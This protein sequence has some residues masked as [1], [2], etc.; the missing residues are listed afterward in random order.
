M[1]TQIDSLD[2]LNSIAHERLVSDHPFKL[3]FD[4]RA[5]YVINNS[6]YSTL[7]SSL[8][9]G[10]TYSQYIDSTSFYSIEDISSLLST[11][12]LYGWNDNTPINSIFF[13]PFSLK[14]FYSDFYSDL[15]PSL[16]SALLT[17]LK[18]TG[19]IVQIGT[20]YGKSLIIK[21]QIMSDVHLQTLPSAVDPSKM[22]QSIQSVA[23]S[24]STYIE[25]NNYLLS[26][27]EEKNNTINYLNN[28]IEEL[29]KRLNLVY[30]TTWR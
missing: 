28:Q 9:N 15:T 24:L 17:L 19:R 26:V 6:S 7:R 21:P 30:Q 23:T 18:T 14:N 5:A 13:Y 12:E 10:L 3:S 11:S 1:I 8:I 4:L 20:G 27:I 25:D 22:I 16:Y 2:L 29:N